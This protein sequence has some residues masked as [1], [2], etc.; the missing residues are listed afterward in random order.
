MYPT[1]H[2]RA[3]HSPL[4]EDLAVID[5]EAASLSQS[6]PS[7]GCPAGQ[8]GARNEWKVVPLDTPGL[9]SSLEGALPYPLMQ[10]GTQVSNRVSRVK[11]YPWTHQLLEQ[12]LSSRN[13]LSQLWARDR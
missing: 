1:S 8:P 4:G 11:K 5:D 10:V 9:P 12:L 2:S 7:Q 6:S 13:F 3:F